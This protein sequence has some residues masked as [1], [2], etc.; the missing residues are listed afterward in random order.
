MFSHNPLLFTV[1][2]CIHILQYLTVDITVKYCSNYK[3]LLQ[4]HLFGLGI[5]V[6]SLTTIAEINYF[7]YFYYSYFFIML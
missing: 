5:L 3:N 7:S 4:C 1:K 6:V 2:Y